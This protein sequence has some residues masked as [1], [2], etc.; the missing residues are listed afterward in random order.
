MEQEERTVH[1][2]GEH[3]VCYF[4]F[5]VKNFVLNYWS[6]FS[7]QQYCCTNS[8]YKSSPLTMKSYEIKPH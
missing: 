8:S 4:K 6:F 5:H 3:T 1:S 2:G 7:R